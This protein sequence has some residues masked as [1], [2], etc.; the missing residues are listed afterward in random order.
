MREQGTESQRTRPRTFRLGIAAIA[1]AS[2]LIAPSIAA[3]KGPLDQSQ[4]VPSCCGGS[5]FISYENRFLAQTF[6]AGRT[7]KLDQIDATVNGDPA[8]GDATFAIHSVSGGV[9]AGSPLASATVP[10]ASLP[11]IFDPTAVFEVP[12]GPVLVTAGTQYAI[13]LSS[14][15]ST[16]A[17][18]VDW[19]FETATGDLYPAGRAFR[20]VNGLSDLFSVDAGIGSPGPPEPTDYAFNTYVSR[21]NTDLTLSMAE[22]ADPATVG[23]NLTYTLSVA[24]RGPD[25]VLGVSVVDTLPPGV[26]FVSAS[27]GCQN[28]AGTVTCNLGQ[29]ND[30]ATKTAQMTVKPSAAGTLTNSARVS[31]PGDDP[32]PSNNNASEDTA[33]VAGPPATTTTTPSTTT[34]PSTTTTT[35]T[36]TTSTQ[37]TTTSTQTTT[38][39]GTTTVPQPDPEVDP[40]FCQGARVTILGTGTSERLRGTSGR[41][42]I[43]GLG[44]IDRIDGLGGDDV[45]CG[46]GSGDEINGNGGDD[47]VS[48]GDGGDSLRGGSGDD[49][50]SGNFGNDEIAGNQGDDGLRGGSGT[51]DECTGGAGDDVDLGGCETTKSAP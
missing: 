49:E 39:P 35:Q 13:V 10:G 46:D 17:T 45:I 44:G 5:A 21:F 24:N 26:T 28:A 8:S 2:A 4:P 32:R 11:G 18:S 48:G 27:G 23:Q 30:G 36:T 33:V 37:T 12:I 15:T 29:L 20:S 25:D 22:S 19:F 42:V 40:A 50:L 47:E 34:A 6:T 3:A 16:S 9:P 43:S 31:A 38:A 14:P 51:G 7:G 41:D 1:C